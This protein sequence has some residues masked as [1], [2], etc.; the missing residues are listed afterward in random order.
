MFTLNSYRVTF[1]LLLTLV[2]LSAAV[3][4]I[5]GAN[6]TNCTSFETVFAEG[7]TEYRCKCPGSHQAFFH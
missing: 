6:S 5:G 4:D 7:S 1:V 2:G 3:S